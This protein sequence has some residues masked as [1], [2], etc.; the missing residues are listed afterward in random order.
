MWP[1]SQEMVTMVSLLGVLMG[2]AALEVWLVVDWLRY[3]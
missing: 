3:K 1:P 2:F